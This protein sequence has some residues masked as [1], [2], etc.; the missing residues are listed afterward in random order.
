MIR[1]RMSARATTDDAPCAGSWRGAT[2]SRAC[3]S[4]GR[5]VAALTV[6]AAV[7]RFARIGHQG[8]GS[9]RR[10]RLCSCTSRPARCSG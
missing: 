3:R 8:S 7:L 1:A 5:D 9:T 6:L 2:R 10:T 4:G